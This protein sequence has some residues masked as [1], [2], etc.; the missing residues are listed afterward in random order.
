MGNII[1]SE[2]RFTYT[3]YMSKERLIDT[4]QSEIQSLNR[5]IDL[6]IIKGFDYRKEAKRHKF[7]ISQLRDLTRPIESTWMDKMVKRVGTFLF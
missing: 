2:L 6:R 1:D 3:I 5:Q 7:L 4:I